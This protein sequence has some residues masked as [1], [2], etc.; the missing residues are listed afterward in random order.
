MYRALFA[1][2]AC[3]A[4]VAF[5]SLALPVM[6]P[7]AAA[8]LGLPAALVGYYTT[9]MLIGATLSTAVAAGFVR[10]YGALRVSQT[11]VALGALGLL[12][13]PLATATP[14]VLPILVASAVL[15]GIAYGPAN[16]ASSHLL[17]RLTPDHL[18]GRIFS[19]KQISIPL[20]GALAGFALP[21]LEARIGWQGAAL[22]ASGACFLVAVALQPMRRKMDADRLPGALLFS[23]GVI[24]SL[25]LV[26]GHRDLRRLAAAS[27]A[28]AAMQFCFFSLFVTFTVER[29]G[30]SLVAV[31]SAFSSGLVVS[32]FARMLWGWVA[33]RFAAS[34]VLAALG[35]GMSASALG[36]SM[37]GPSWPY[38]GVVALA[39]A[40]GST[41]TAWQGVYL[42][43]VARHA[44]RD[45]IAEATAGCMSVTFLCALIG[46]AMFSAVIELSG[47][48]AAGFLFVGAITLAFGIAF[49][50]RGP[51][52]K[53]G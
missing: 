9:V 42:A 15:V 25:R 5:A 13:L 32:I 16:P 21:L 22:A 4:S 48:D 36:A 3:Q 23:G 30:F 6:A 12:G 31:G 26:L 50:V 14:A 49:I 45:R 2:L 1:M 29:T 27:G 37:L 47:N 53:A 44:P 35:L 19:I 41:A 51:S 33:D 38:F 18:R 11:T 52:R 40:M 20:G 7:V 8:A 39:V 24:S 43:E 46:P 34:H 28:F 10:R 17:A